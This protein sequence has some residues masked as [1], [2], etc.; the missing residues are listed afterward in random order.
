[1]RDANGFKQ[2]T[3]SEG[4]V[5]QM[6]IV[7]QDANKFINDYSNQFKSDFLSLLRTSHGEKKVNINHFYNEYIANK[8]HVH[9]NATKWPSLTEFAKFL[10]REGICRVDEGDRGLEIS[11]V[12][13]SPEALRR[14]AAIQ[15]KERQ[16]KGDEEREQR[17]IQAQ[18][19]RAKRDAAAKHDPD[20]EAAPAHTE[21]QREG[22]EKIKLSFAP[23]KAATA[24]I[25]TTVTGP[26][27][28]QGSLPE[29]DKATVTT[30]EVAEVDGNDLDK[31]KPSQGGDSAPPP[32]KFSFSSTNKPKNVFAAK[33]NAFSAVKP[34][35][36][37]KS[38]RPMS[39]AERIMR[40]ELDQKRR[41]E[42][43]GAQDG[44]RKRMR[45]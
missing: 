18:I 17:L 45:L 39:E 15:K 6:Q 38:D 11:W 2:H 22:D 1:M 35:V 27:V 19:E 36:K 44:Q 31:T 3:L 9:M 41:R 40:D 8:D 12:D 43:R 28:Q 26:L 30:Q 32:A 34:A 14:Q 37:A 24:P 23:A 20:T 21:L 16:D 13:T 4:H 7:G 33:K 10:G 5:R 29:P 25:A 42:G